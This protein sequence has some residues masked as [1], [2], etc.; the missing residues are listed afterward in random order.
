MC[1]AHHAEAPVG[2]A[3]ATDADQ[4]HKPVTR[5]PEFGAN[6]LTEDGHVIAVKEAPAESEENEEADGHD[7]RARVAHAKEGGQEEAHAECADEDTAAFRALHP[8]VGQPAADPDA[9]EGSNLDVEH[10]R[11]PRLT[12]AE[13]ELFTKNIGHP[14]FHDPARECRQREVEHEEQEVAVR[15][16]FVEC[17]EEARGWNSRLCAGGRIPE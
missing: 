4:V 13:A 12:L 14:V 5:G 10:S 16:K 3:A 8:A 9:D 7:E 15:E 17:T 1:I 2:Q 11:H 6:E